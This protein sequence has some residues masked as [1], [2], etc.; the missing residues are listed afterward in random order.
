MTALTNKLD[1]ASGEWVKNRIASGPA[2]YA[3]KILSAECM[4]KARA[5]LVNQGVERPNADELKAWVLLQCKP[6]Y[7]AFCVSEAYQDAAKER[8]RH[9]MAEITVEQSKLQGKK[10]EAHLSGYQP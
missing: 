8:C 6:E 9:L 2:E 5:S 3:Y 10:T 7:E 4:L 1:K